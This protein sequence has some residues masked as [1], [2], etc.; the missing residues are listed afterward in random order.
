VSSR[1]GVPGR[2]DKS[3]YYPARTDFDKFAD[4]IMPCLAQ[5]VWASIV[6]ENIYYCPV[7]S[8]SMC[9][10]PLAEPDFLYLSWRVRNYRNP[11][12]IGSN[13]D[14][15]FEKKKCGSANHPE[16][17][18]W[19]SFTN[20]VKPPEAAVSPE[21]TTYFGR[22]SRHRTRNKSQRPGNH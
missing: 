4:D 22:E 11:S 9:L 14:T 2:V 20:R 8:F 13:I 16:S 21:V 3:R 15:T 1:C 12:S 6:D 17:V 19:T 5:A 7:K 18:F 10:H